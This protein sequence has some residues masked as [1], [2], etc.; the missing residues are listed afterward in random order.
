MKKQL[1]SLALV[2]FMA[3]TANAQTVVFSED[4][5]AGSQPSGWTQDSAGQQPQAPWFFNDP[6]A[7]AGTDVT[8]ANFDANFMIFDS[9]FFGSGATQ[10]ASITTPS[11]NCSAIS[12]VYIIMDESYRSYPGQD[13]TLEVSADGGATWTTF[14]S[15]NNTNGYPTATTVGI[16]IS[17][18]AANQANVQLRFFLTATYGWWWAIDNLKVQDQIFACSAPLAGTTGASAN[19]ACPTSSTTLSLGGASGGSGLTYQWFDSPDGVTFTAI[20]GATNATYV[21]NITAT[22]YYH[23]TLDCGG[24]QATSTD[25]QVTVNPIPGCQCYPINPVCS[26]S[27]Y[28]SNVTLNT[29]N[30]TS[31]CDAAN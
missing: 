2:G 4:F 23:C 8:G 31:T 16:D 19:P 30:N 3:T 18:V 25:L 6:G 28:I 24:T 9:D 12:S 10:G 20:A 29:L 14:I 7:R 21:T 22:T 13:H 26:G 17:S 11:I 5:T 27:D 15:G 1:L